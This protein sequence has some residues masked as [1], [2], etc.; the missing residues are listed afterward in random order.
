MPE[1]DEA[2]TFKVLLNAYIKGK[3]NERIIWEKMK[4]EYK[5]YVADTKETDVTRKKVGTDAFFSSL[6]D[7]FEVLL[8]Q[9]F[10]A[11]DSGEIVGI[12]S[13]STMSRVLDSLLLTED[14]NF[15]SHL[16]RR[17]SIFEAL[18]NIPMLSSKNNTDLTKEHYDNVTYLLEGLIESSQGLKALRS[19][20]LK[21]E[22]VL[23]CLK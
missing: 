19:Q 15:S 2:R 22:T 21:S 3:G 10:V 13:S 17:E 23:E 6:A 14:E 7:H 20:V 4:D 18:L 8:G 9:L 12:K 5:K 11:D 1:K 16:S